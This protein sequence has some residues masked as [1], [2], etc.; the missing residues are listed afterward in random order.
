MANSPGNRE[1]TGRFS[2]GKSGNPSGRPA[3]PKSVKDMLK[4]A[5]K[6]A[7]QLLIDTVGNPEAKLDM[8]IRCAET[9]LDRVYGKAS[10]P[11]EGGLTVAKVDL[12]TDDDASKALEALGYVRK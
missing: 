7:A 5:T 4:A 9:I 3:T 1:K 11:I 2:K 12:I 6:E 8:R 10:Q